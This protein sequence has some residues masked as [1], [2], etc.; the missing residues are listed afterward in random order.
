ML[1]RS[2]YPAARTDLEELAGLQKWL[3]SYKLEELFNEDDSI[4]DEIL[5]VLLTD[6]CKRLGQRKLI[7]AGY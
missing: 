3:K 4:T 7:S 5:R 2:P 1:I 6:Q